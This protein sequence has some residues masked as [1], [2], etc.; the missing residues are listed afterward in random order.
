M[1]PHI[2]LCVV[3]VALTFAYKPKKNIYGNNGTNFLEKSATFRNKSEIILIFM[4][5]Y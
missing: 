5:L 3:L 2:I 1:I 4:K